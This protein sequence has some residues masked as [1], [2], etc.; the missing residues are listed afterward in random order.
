LH[1]D[2]VDRLNDALM[3]VLEP[4]AGILL[5]VV[6]VVLGG[7]GA[8][9]LRRRYRSLARRRRAKAAAG[10]IGRPSDLLR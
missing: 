10:A 6:P 9:A 7:L 3:L 2:H 8:R 1:V 4:A 5:L